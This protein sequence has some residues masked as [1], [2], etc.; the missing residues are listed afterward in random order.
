MRP[1]DLLF[2]AFARAFLM[3]F[4]VPHLI[5]QIVGTAQ[6]ACS[7]VGFAKPVRRADQPGRLSHP[8]RKQPP[9]SQRLIWKL[10][11][12]RYQ[13]C[14]FWPFEIFVA[15]L[16]NREEFEG[17]EKREKEEKNDKTHVKIPL[18]SLNDHKKNTKTGKNFRGGEGGIFLAG[19]NIYPCKRTSR[20]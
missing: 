6:Q 19:Q 17:R 12:G 14:I 16:Q 2:S 15:I 3:Y 4:L 18:W 13:G 9:I 7:I 20:M 11:L 10:L 5:N 1:V 8:P